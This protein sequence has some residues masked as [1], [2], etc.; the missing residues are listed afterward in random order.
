MSY[1]EQVATGEGRYELLDALEAVEAA[2]PVQAVE[3]VTTRL[4]AALQTDR[5]AFLIADLAG[6]ALVRLEHGDVAAPGA[7]SAPSRRMCCR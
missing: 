7:G 5:V 4:A 6:R 3:S 2:S 1:F